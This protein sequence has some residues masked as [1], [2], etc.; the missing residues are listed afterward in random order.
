[1]EDSI[2]KFIAVDGIDPDIEAHFR[3]ISSVENAAGKHTHDFFE[4]FLILKGSVIHCVNGKKQLLKENSL[5]FIRDEDIHYYEQTEKSD[6]QF[7]NLSFYK[8][9]IDSLFEYLG[10]GFSKD[11]LLNPEMPPVVVLSK[12]EKQYIQNR[13]ESLNLI[14]NS[15]K[16]LVKAEVRALLA[17]LFS[18]YIMDMQAVYANNHPEWLNRLCSVMKEKDNFVEGIPALLRISG[19]THSYIC[20]M[21]KQYLSLSPVEYINGLRL[22]YAENLLLNT[23]MDIID[24][25]LEVGFEN[26]SYF[27]ELFKKHFKTT[28]HKFRKENNKNMF[29]PRVVG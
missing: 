27:Y 1:M 24:I 28:P 11:I 6:C 4:I 17:E 29:C 8:T 26:M 13:L 3:F 2:L 18:R 20:K 23:D 12:P 16:S 22:S 21:F 9:V 10:E 14:P 19:K 5:V 15:R 7:I 25:C